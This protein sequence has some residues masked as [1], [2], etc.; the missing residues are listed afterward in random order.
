[1][2]SK[3][4]ELSSSNVKTLTLPDGAVTRIG[5]G[6]AQCIAFSSDENSLA[7]ASSIGLWIYDVSTMNPVALWETESG[8][9]STVA[10]SP[11]GV[12]LATGN[13]DGEVKLWDIQTQSCVSK[14]KRFDGFDED[15]SQIVFSRDGHRVAFSGKRYGI[16]Y[17]W[18]S[19]TWE[20][21]EK[22]TVESVS[23]KGDRAFIPLSI[24]PN[25]KFV[26]CVTSE[27]SFSLWD[28][29]EGKCVAYPA[30]AY[31]SYRC[32]NLFTLWTVLNLWR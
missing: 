21:G 5:R 22:F 8:L 23:E 6:W 17:I 3:P 12:L 32:T 19:R 27:N 14:M 9:V 26:A 1:M 28:I 24:S 2:M 18:D 13:W 11:D 20:Q 31:C 29:E 4:K 30:V 25:G 16:F 7:V 10:F 15:V